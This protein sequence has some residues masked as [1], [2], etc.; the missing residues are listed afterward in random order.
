MESL[1]F[2]NI[3][4][5]AGPAQEGTMI[6]SVASGKGGTGKTTIVTNLAFSLGGDAQLLDCDVEAPNAH[7][8]IKPVMR[9]TQTVTLAVPHVDLDKCTLCGQCADICRYKAIVKLGATVLAF[10]ELC[11]ACGG[12]LRVCPEKA[13]RETGRELGVIEH[14]ERNGLRFIHGRSRVGEPMSPPL[15]RKVRACA[16]RMG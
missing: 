2:L 8:F 11:H 9:Q 13:I 16:Y 7:L 12:C 10:P 15:I 3:H 6:I 1:G 14:G 5:P 4:R